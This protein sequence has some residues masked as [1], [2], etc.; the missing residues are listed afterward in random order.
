ML[1]RTSYKLYPI[2]LEVRSRMINDKV[3]MNEGSSDI[4]N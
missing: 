4:K 2:L 3:L 1:E